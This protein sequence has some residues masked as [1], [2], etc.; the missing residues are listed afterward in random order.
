MVRFAAVA[1]VVIGVG[2][3]AWALIAQEGEPPGEASGVALPAPEKDGRVSVEKALAGRRSV[4]AYGEG[5]LTLA[6]VSQ[7]LW[8]AQGVTNPRGFRTAPSAGAL[9]PLEVYLV[10]A[11]VTGL[12]AGVYRY[13][14]REHDLTKVLDGDR[15]AE[16]A[17]AALRQT[18]IEDGAAVLV[19]AAVYERTAKKYGDRAVRY[20]HMEVGHAAQNV[21]LQAGALGLGTVMIGAFH[22]DKVRKVLGMG[23]DERPLGIMPVGRRD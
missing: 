3:L 8:A 20:V 18:A 12:P 22:D 11:N 7:L 14:P 1:T 17:A 23:E 15:R 9:Y 4:R 19:I 10:A 5:P 6:E 21:Y 16:L 2:V 13:R